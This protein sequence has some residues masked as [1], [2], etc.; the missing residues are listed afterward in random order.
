M[1]WKTLLHHFH[2]GIISDSTSEDPKRLRSSTSRPTELFQACTTRRN[3][4]NLASCIAPYIVAKPSSTFSGQSQW[5]FT[6][7]QT[8]ARCICPGVSHDSIVT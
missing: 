7:R 6:R 4:T 1:S 8:F 2:I 5:C 3:S